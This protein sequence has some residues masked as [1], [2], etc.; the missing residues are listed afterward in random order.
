M[1]TGPNPTRR[2]LPRGP[3]WA[4]VLAAGLVATPACTG[5]L[6]GYDPVTSQ[7]ETITDLFSLTNVL[8]LLVALL[9]AGV[10]GYVLLR[11]RARRPGEPSR[12]HEHRALEITW[13]AT[14]AVLLAGLFVVTVLVMVDVDEDPPPAENPLLVQVVGN[15]WW[16]EFRYPELGVV[17]ANELH[18][19]VGRPIRFEITGDDVIHSFWVPR[20][21]RKM[22]AI[23]GRTNVMTVTVEEP[24][25]YQ[26]ACTEFCGLQHAWMRILVVAQTP[27]EF[28]AWVALQQA[29]A[30]A[31]QSDVALQGRAVFLRNTCINCHA[32]QGTIAQGQV[33]PDL[34][35]LGSRQILGAGVVPNTP[36][37]LKRFIRNA[38][39]VKPGV[40]MPQF[41]TLSDE[42]LEAL[43]AYLEGL[44]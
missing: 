13:T 2:R 16:W 21:G 35:H 20:F 38:Q 17:T 5:R 7:G 18:V 27:Q 29:P 26:G 4:A 19:P 15:N 41:Q 34:T 25:T 12:V 36:E 33:G 30:R 37:N 22:D 11:Y 23:P 3:R 43:V 8:G 1:P 24:G 28:Q 42:D 9:V 44:E 40:L 10:L 6:D 14:P 39:E 31:P 32:I